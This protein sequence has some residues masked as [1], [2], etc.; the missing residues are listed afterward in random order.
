MMTAETM[1]SK[2]LVVRITKAIFFL[3]KLV[4]LVFFL[5]DQEHKYSPKIA[6]N[7]RKLCL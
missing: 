6:A 5:R 4:L 3:L 2:C 1:S 7:A